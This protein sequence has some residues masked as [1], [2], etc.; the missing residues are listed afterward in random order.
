MILQCGGGDIYYPYHIFIYFSHIFFWNGIDNC[1]NGFRRYQNKKVQIMV[2]I[3]CVHALVISKLALQCS[4]VCSS[5][6]FFLKILFP[7]VTICY[8]FI[9]CNSHFLFCQKLNWVSW[10][11]HVL[12]S[13]ILVQVRT[14]KVSNVS[15]V[16]SEIDIREFFS[17]SGDVEY[18]ETRRL[19]PFP[20]ITY[21][22]LSS[23]MRFGAW[24]LS[25][26]M[27]HFSH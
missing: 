7:F 18:V 24:N 11:S 2:K 10:W 16:A 9:M 15:L 3:Q 26:N 25:Q 5:F 1:R 27:S 20:L 19:F 13:C 8:N 4:W 22:Y 14:V 17:F 23:E 6:C 12:L 21:L